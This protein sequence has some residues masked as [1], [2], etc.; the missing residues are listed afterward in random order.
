MDVMD[1]DPLSLLKFTYKYNYYQEATNKEVQEPTDKEF[2]DA[3][4]AYKEF[5]YKYHQDNPGTT[6]DCYK[7]YLKALGK[8]VGVLLSMALLQR[9]IGVLCYGEGY[10]SEL[11]ER[12]TNEYY[13]ITH[14]SI[15]IYPFEQPWYAAHNIISKLPVESVDAAFFGAYYDPHDFIKSILEDLDSHVENW[16]KETMYANYTSVTQASGMGK[17]RM[18]KQLA[19]AGVYVIYCCLRL[20][21]SGYPPQSHI[22]K[23]LLHSHDDLHFVA[24]FIACLNKLA[25]T[26]D[27]N[28]IDWYNQQISRGNDGASQE[29][30]REFWDDIRLRM[31]KLKR[32]LTDG[33]AS[34][35][36]RQSYER[37]LRTYPNIR[38][39]P[40]PKNILRICFVFDE[41]RCLLP[42]TEKSGSETADK[43]LAF[44]NMRRALVHF[45]DK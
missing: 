38:N 12:Q 3:Y 9:V 39:I 41:A 24:Y 5:F 22:T 20:S 26:P 2:E 31:E 27:T 13:H 44:Y 15:F 33:N 14:I 32:S 43:N 19:E 28:S 4:E 17:S 25:D 7:E 35:S 16:I 21:G 40:L 8:Q 6:T 11:P 37:A 36:L 29:N 10:I 45:D 34:A 30:A 18:V 23:Y 42:I 1:V